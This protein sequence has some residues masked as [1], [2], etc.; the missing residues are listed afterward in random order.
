MPNALTN[1][2]VDFV[3]LVD[4]AAVRDPNSPAD[5]R[6]F[7]VWKREGDSTPEGGTMTEQEMRAAVE[8]AERET[9]ELRKQLEDQTTLKADLA[10]AEKERD[11]ALA[12][13]AGDDKPEPTQLDKSQLAPEV[14]EALEKAEQREQEANERIAK[15]EKDAKDAADLAKAERDARVTREFIAKAE[16]D[17]PLVGGNADE[18][19]PILKAASEALPEDVYKALETRLAAAEEQVRA[20]E[21]L[22][23]QGRGGTAPKDGSAAAEVTRKAEELRKSDSTLRL[24]QAMDRVLK[25]DTDLQ[26]RYV[27]E[28]RG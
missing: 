2:Q 13:A 22:K 15:A 12:K 25:A 7:L 26:A 20:G 5:P 17:Y 11:D 18:F 1:V 3:S 19:G 6:R 28:M 21:L 16:S 23:E 24:D 8:K 10:K 9:T 4:R 14:R 27:A